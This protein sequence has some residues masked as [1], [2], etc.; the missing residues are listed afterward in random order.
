M[1]D[2][3][4]YQGREQTFVK[5]F[6]LERYLER[7][8]YVT[9]AGGAWS[10]FA[11][12]DAFSGPWRSGDEN[13]RDTSVFIALTKLEAVR[14]GLQKAGRDVTFRALFVER[15]QSAFQ[16]LRRL[17]ARFPNSG[18]ITICGEFQDHIK[19]A[20]RFI[21]NAFSL[22]FVDPTGWSVDLNALQP[23]LRL[24][25]EVIINFMYNDI[26]RHLLENPQASVR[27]SFDPIFGGLSWRSEIEQRIAGGEDREAAILGVFCNRLR[28]AGSFEYVTST[29]V[30]QPLVERTYFYLVY[31]T[32]HW[33]GVEE[34]RSVEEKAVE[35]QES[36]RVDAKL[37]AREERSRMRDLFPDETPPGWTPDL[38][39]RRK[40][41]LDAARKRLRELSAKKKEFGA[42]EAFGCM[43]E[44]PLVFP[45]DARTLLLEAREAK[46]VT[47]DLTPRQKKPA[48]NTVV[49]SLISDGSR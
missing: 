31:A 9:L 39:D 10:E 24:R 13:F 29:R 30:M 47:F 25:G 32:R 3:S 33:K 28:A 37:D 7:V 18:A 5:H 40:R 11:Y 26:N 14:Q 36:V 16:Y 43:L 1:L 8:A 23:L 17:V 22:I 4:W 46:W 44:Q 19:E 6:F 42:F 38:H 35:A 21:N 34:F 41:S 2:P 27:A 45:A 49:T 15:D 20:R 12:V 48:P